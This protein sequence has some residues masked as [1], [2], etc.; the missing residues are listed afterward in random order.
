MGFLGIGAH[1]SRLL[2]LT[3]VLNVDFIFIVDTDLL[4]LKATSRLTCT[5]AGML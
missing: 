1:V 2:T 3:T 5:Y 4:S